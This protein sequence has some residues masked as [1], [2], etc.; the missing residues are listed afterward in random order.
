MRRVVYA[1]AMAEIIKKIEPPFT[2]GIFGRWGSGKS[3]FLKLIKGILPAF[4]LFFQTMCS[5]A[6]ASLSNIALSQ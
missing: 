5:I 1:E 2:I 4:L 3:F 6:F